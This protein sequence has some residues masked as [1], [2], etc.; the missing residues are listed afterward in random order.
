MDKKLTQLSQLKKRLDIALGNYQ[1]NHALWAKWLHFARK[2]DWYDNWAY[3]QAMRQSDLKADHRDISKRFRNVEPEYKQT[4]GAIYWSERHSF[5]AELD[6]LR[7]ARG[8]LL[9][10]LWTEKT[11]DG[12]WKYSLSQIA[13]AYGNTDDA[14]Y[15]KLKV[16]EWFYPRRSPGQKVVS[17]NTRKD[18]Q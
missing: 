7:M 18:L 2:Q 4:F 12:K 17:I 8:K 6:Q 13:R 11:E 10:D 5:H 14:M 15:K 1:R 9:H 16:N 3:E